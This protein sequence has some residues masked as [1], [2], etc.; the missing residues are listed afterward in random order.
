MHKAHRK[1]I[2]HLILLKGNIIRGALTALLVKTRYPHTGGVR[3][4]TACKH[5][6]TAPARRPQITI[7][8]F[9]YRKLNKTK[10]TKNTAVSW[11]TGDTGAAKPPS[12][13][14]YIVS[15]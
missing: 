10:Q 1:P 3:K 9:L 7:A 12:H 15:A 14:A 8:S 6:L 2:E 5:R 4:H 13:M 11:H